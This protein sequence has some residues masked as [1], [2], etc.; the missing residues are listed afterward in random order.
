MKKAEDADPE[1]ARAVG[2]SRSCM[3]ADCLRSTQVR[4]PPKFSTTKR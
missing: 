1:D 2:P 4:I 3:M